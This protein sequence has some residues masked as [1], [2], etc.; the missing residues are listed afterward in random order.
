MAKLLQHPIAVE[1]EADVLPS[2]D[3][4]WNPGE[5][6][7]REAAKLQILHGVQ[8][9]VGLARRCFPRSTAQS[10][11]ILT[12]HR[13]AARTGGVPFPTINVTPSRFRQQLEGLQASGFEFVSLSRVL[14]ACQSAETAAA[15]PER[16]VIVT[17]DDIFD[18]VFTQAC[19]V[20]SELQIPATFFISTAFIDREEPF[21]FDPWAMKY[22]DVVPA[23]AWRPLTD[24]H[25]RSM[26]NSELC[27]IGAHTHTHQD[28]RNRP[29]EFAVDL[30]R[31]VEILQD[32]YDVCHLP[33]AFPYGS[34]RLGFSA[35]PLMNAVRG[36][37]LTCGLT[38]G[39]HTN[40][41]STSPF[42]WGRFHVFQHDTPLS[43]EA[44][45]TGACEWLP[46]IKNKLH[47][48]F[49]TRQ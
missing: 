28:F 37:R 11:S 33:F 38:T 22:R 40:G 48:K 14:E 27:E 32:R 31:S 3:R 44:R 17:F 16:T 34:P 26:L 45:I 39:S 15:L 13:I 2:V 30:Q 49:G 47:S 36:C 46:R 24:E 35:E 9:A 10:I 19:P 12:Y 21:L 5:E 43:L 20:L 23:D 1:F 18:N 7:W 4:Y 6:T 29:A 8:R 41:R 25:L 42:G